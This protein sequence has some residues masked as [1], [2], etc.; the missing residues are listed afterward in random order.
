[1]KREGYTISDCADIYDFSHNKWSSRL[2]K[3]PTRIIPH[4]MAGNLTPQSFSSIMHGSRTM[5]PTVSV[6]TDGT[7][8]AWVPE[9][10]RP[11]TSGS[12]EAD[13]PALT[14]E[15][16][17]DSGAERNWHI[18]DK[19]YNTAVEV[20]A[21]W[22]ILY[23]IDPVYSYR[24]KGINMHKDWAAT[25]CPGPYLEQKIKSGTLEKDI[26]AKMVELQSNPN[27]EKFVTNA[28]SKVLGRKPDE[29]GYAY[30]VSAI[31]QKSVP[32]KDILFGFFK[33]KEYA[34]KKKEDE[35]FVKDCYKAFLQRS[36]DKKG[37]TYWTNA[38]KTGKT[39]TDVLNGFADSNEFKSW[40]K[41]LG[42]K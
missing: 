41:S 10:M 11:W 13:G 5:S 12:Y 37:L 31:A 3:K 28:Y 39:R 14:L 6:H 15:I 22:C 4:H 29:S 20:M 32:C 38:L 23:G 40:V 25:A 9:E 35:D 8:I 24:G 33:S 26:R 1:M 27:V 30:W 21:R 34:D 17:N 19:A 42:L 7:V 36:Y 18:S 2:G 16:A